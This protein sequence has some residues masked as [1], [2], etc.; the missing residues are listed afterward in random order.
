MIWSHSSPHV[1]LQNGGEGPELVNGVWA[2]GVRHG[3]SPGINSVL[4]IYLGTD[5][6]CAYEPL[7][8]DDRLR[9]AFPYKYSEMMRLI[10]PYL[11]VD[12]EPDWKHNLAEEADRFAEELRS[13][14]PELDEIAVRALANR[15]HFGW[16]R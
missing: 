16:S 12:R 11:E 10:T 5:G 2:R 14:F 3:M 4:K 6:N 15:W 1:R 7:Y 13:R 8:S 9:Q